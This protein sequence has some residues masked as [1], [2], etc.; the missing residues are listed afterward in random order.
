ME[1]KKIVIGMASMDA[2]DTY[3]SLASEGYE[4]HTT[5]FV[6]NAYP[7]IYTDKILVK[8]FDETEIVICMDY[9]VQ[10]G[11]ESKVGIN[12]GTAI[13][14]AM[15]SNMTL[16]TTDHTTEMVCNTLGVSYVNADSLKKTHTIETMRQ[17]SRKIN[18]INLND[19]QIM[20]LYASGMTQPSYKPNI[21][22]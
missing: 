8:E 7:H 11:L 21:C 22:L 20:R 2:F 3:R 13:Y 14:Y 16:L 9:I 17:T 6:K 5:A 15:S 12:D 18:S 4:F 19:E 10:N 1:R